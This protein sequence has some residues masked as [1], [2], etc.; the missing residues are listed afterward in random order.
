MS[1]EDFGFTV[2][3]NLK[4]SYF[5]VQ[6]LLPLMTSGGSV[7]LNTSILGSQGRHG[8]SVYS[9]TKA[10]LRSLARSLTAELS[11]KGIRVNA[12]APGQI[13]TDI[14]RKVRMS[15]EMIEQVRTQA[16]AQSPMGRTG[17]AGEIA[18]AALFLASDEAAYITG[19]ELSGDGGWAQV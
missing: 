9:A 14:M 3:T 4:D 8:F 7:I 15:D 5:T 2:N 11:D 19:V 1:E 10:A 16:S 17:S 6:K 12:L 18:G 13:D